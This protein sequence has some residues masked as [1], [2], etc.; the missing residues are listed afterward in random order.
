[1]FVFLCLVSDVCAERVDYRGFIDRPRPLSSD[2][3]EDDENT[4][5]KN[6]TGQP[7]A[8][9]EVLFRSKNAPDR[10]T[11]DDFYFAHR[12]LGPDHPLPDSDLLKAI[13][14]YA[15]DFY[16]RATTNG[17]STTCKAWTER[18]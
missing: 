2:E 14:A 17:G 9:D 6:Q 13:H 16:A 3:D 4:R 11:E 15:S 8:P 10:F 1:M 18:R 7:L 5:K 12:D